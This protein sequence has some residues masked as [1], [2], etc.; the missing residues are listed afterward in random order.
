MTA[1]VKSDLKRLNQ[2]Y[3]HANLS[4]QTIQKYHD[5]ATTLLKDGF[6]GT[7]TYG[8]QQEVEQWFGDK[9]KEWVVALKYEVINGELDGGSDTP[10]GLRPGCDVDGAKFYS[11]LTYS[12]KWNSDMNGQEQIDYKNSKLPIQRGS[13][14]EPEAN[15]SQDRSYGKGGQVMNRYTTYPG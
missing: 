5:E 11:F 10:G 14:T 1:R 7:V 3:P 13:G 2:L 15:W 9:K 4:E 12:P 6:L 8:F